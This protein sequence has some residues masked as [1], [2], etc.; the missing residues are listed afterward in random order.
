VNAIV[1]CAA[2]LRPS[3][4]PALRVETAGTATAQELVEWGADFSNWRP[5]PEECDAGCCWQDVTGLENDKVR[6]ARPHRISDYF[7]PSNLAILNPKPEYLGKPSAG[8]E[9]ES[10]VS[11]NGHRLAQI[12]PYAEMR[13][14]LA[15]SCVRH[16]SLAARPAQTRQTGGQQTGGHK[17]GERLTI[18]GLVC[19]NLFHRA[20]TDVLGRVLP[21]AAW[22]AV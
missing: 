17:Q 13:L 16:E 5:F 7:C 4:R 22:M 15:P 21:G 12:E 2:K 11:I 6:V 20:G 10:S 1:I 9:G 14:R 18:H 19:Y 3:S 8:S